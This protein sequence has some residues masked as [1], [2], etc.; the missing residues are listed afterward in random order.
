MPVTIVYVELVTADGQM[1]RV[2]RNSN[3]NLRSN[4][5]GAAWRMGG[6]GVRGVVGGWRDGMVGGADGVWQG[7]VHPIRTS[8]RHPRYLSPSA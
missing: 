2:N 1:Q 5:R 4:P 8:R 7:R 6:W 3:R